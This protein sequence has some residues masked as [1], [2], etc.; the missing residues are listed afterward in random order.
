MRRRE[1]ANTQRRYLKMF[2]EISFV[3]GARGSEVG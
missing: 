3:E 1:N 2:S